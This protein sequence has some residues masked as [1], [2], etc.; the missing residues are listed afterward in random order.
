MR[1]RDRKYTAHMATNNN[2]A[3]RVRERDEGLKG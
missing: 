3:S 2:D 1:G